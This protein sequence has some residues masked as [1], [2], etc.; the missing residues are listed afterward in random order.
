MKFKSDWNESERNMK[1]KEMEVRAL[2]TTTT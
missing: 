2:I 1:I